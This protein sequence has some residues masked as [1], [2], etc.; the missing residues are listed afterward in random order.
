MFQGDK[1]RPNFILQDKENPESA[2]CKY[3]DS[4]SNAP[5]SIVTLSCELYRQWYATASLTLILINNG[6]IWYESK[7]IFVLDDNPFAGRTNSTT[8]NKVHG[9]NMGPTWVL[10]TQD[11]SRVGPMN[12]SIR[13][14][15]PSV[16]MI[17]KHSVPKH[18]LMIKNVSDFL[19]FYDSRNFRFVFIGRKVCNYNRRGINSSYIWFLAEKTAYRGLKI[20]RSPME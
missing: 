7:Q 17:N 16:T 10:S 3:R 15:R 18:D 4:T 5:L 8:K 14:S 13:D 9:A 19:L 2:N 6:A 1:W 11:G 20:Y 12:L